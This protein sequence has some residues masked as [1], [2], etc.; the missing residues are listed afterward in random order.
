VNYLVSVLIG[1]FDVEDIGVLLAV[2]VL[3]IL[4]LG[5]DE[6]LGGPCVEHSVLH[7]WT[8]HKGLAGINS[9]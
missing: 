7:T 2:D 1:D 5:L 9:N 4:V 6:E 8:K 3:S